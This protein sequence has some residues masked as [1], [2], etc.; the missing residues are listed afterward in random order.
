MFSSYSL[1]VT[2]KLCPL[3]EGGLSQII[4]RFGLIQHPFVLVLIKLILRTP[5]KNKPPCVIKRA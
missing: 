5:D 4:N 1:W 3:K 2:Q